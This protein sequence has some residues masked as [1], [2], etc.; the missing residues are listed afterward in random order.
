M[1]NSTSQDY[2]VPFFLLSKPKRIIT[3]KRVASLWRNKAAPNK[4][5]RKVRIIVYLFP[6]QEGRNRER[7]TNFVSLYVDS[8][9]LEIVKRR[10]CNVKFNN[11]VMYPYLITGDL[12]GTELPSKQLESRDSFAWR[13]IIYSGT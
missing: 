10:L 1:I 8:F 9:S 4:H 13:F 11:A 6:L 12:K 5:V 3:A 7:N 2:Y